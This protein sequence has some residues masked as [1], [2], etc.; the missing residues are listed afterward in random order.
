MKH[1]EMF[2]LLLPSVWLGLQSFEQ[3]AEVKDFTV[4]TCEYIDKYA[5]NPDGTQ[6]T[7]SLSPTT[8]A[9]RPTNWDFPVALAAGL[10][11]SEKNQPRS[12][13]G[14]LACDFAVE[15]VLMTPSSPFIVEGFRL[16]RKRG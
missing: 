2:I 5:I 6:K 11:H 14:R 4:F 12:F 10:T 7:Q 1:D 13:R 3:H 15:H 16:R 9:K 8:Y